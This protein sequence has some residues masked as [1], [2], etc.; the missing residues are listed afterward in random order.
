V[1]ETT[2]LFPLVGA[3][4]SLFGISLFSLFG[5][6]WKLTVFA[7]LHSFDTEKHKTAKT[8]SF[9]IPPKQCKQFRGLRHCVIHECSGFQAAL[10]F[11]V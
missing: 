1:I 6:I 10:G 8:V 2:E 7:I 3:L 5:S 9:Q 11:R 4:F